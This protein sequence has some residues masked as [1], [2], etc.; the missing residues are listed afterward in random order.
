[1]VWK[2]DESST[3]QRG[4]VQNDLPSG[5]VSCRVDLVDLKASDYPVAQL[6]TRKIF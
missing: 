5:I 3:L 4:S 1:M 2:I 6:F